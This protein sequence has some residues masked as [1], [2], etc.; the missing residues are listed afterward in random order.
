MSRVFVV[1][2]LEDDQVM[3]YYALTTGSVL[4]ADVPARLTQG[5]GQFDIPGR[6][7]YAARRRHH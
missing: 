3:G 4:K 6:R 5:T 1:Q 2:R 7:P